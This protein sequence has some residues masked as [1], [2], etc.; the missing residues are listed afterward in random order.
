MTDLIVT[1]EQKRTDTLHAIAA[2]L[3]KLNIDAQLEVAVATLEF[4]EDIEDKTADDLRKIKDQSKLVDIIDGN[5]YKDRL[6]NLFTE[7]FAVMSDEH[8]KEYLD[9][10]IYEEAIAEVNLQIVPALEEVQQELLYGVFSK[11]TLQ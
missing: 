9:G 4:L 2:R 11:P 1:P 10:L 7:K 8:L 3:A 5:E 6:Q